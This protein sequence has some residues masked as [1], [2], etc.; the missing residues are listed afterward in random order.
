[1]SRKFDL[2]LFM[3]QSNMAGRGISNK[4]WPEGA[5]DIIDDAGYEFRA[6]SDP[7]KLYAIN[8]P[9]GIYEN[10]PEAIWEPGMKT[11]SMVTSFVNAY[12]IHTGIPII[13]VS[14]SKGGSVI[15]QW[16]NCNDYLTDAMERLMKAQKYCKK[17]NITLRHLYMVWCQGESD[18][19]HGTEVLEYRNKFEY[20]L[21]NMVSVGIEMCF[22]ISIGQYNGTKST[23]Y[24][25]LIR[26]QH[27]IALEH[28]K[29]WLVSD[30]FAN[31]K[32]RGLMKDDFHYY[33]AA[34]NE[35]GRIAG[36]NTADYVCKKFR[37]IL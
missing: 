19:D 9:F 25:E 28:P 12:Y 5:P 31:M 13:A 34:Y 26:I 7:E 6:V 29:V 33:Q 36:K 14:A 32:D 3:G 1:M 23:D 4:K 2:F 35:V 15:A 18:G 22:L 21:Q 16:Q 24:G 37:E 30:D 20:M 8:E 10:N 11:G 17:N 27:E